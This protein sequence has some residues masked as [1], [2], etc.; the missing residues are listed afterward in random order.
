MDEEQNKAS[1]VYQLYQWPFS[2]RKQTYFDP[3]VVSLPQ[4]IYQG[5]E[6]TAG[7]RTGFAGHWGF[8][9]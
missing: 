9:T 1:S 4:N 8:K 6:T 7:N 3:A 2:Q 5:R